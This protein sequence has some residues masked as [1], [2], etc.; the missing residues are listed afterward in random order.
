MINRCY[1][2]KILLFYQ[3]MLSLESRIYIFIMFV[4]KYFRIKLRVSFLKIKY[5]LSEY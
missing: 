5:R 1:L 2:S 4:I 3:I